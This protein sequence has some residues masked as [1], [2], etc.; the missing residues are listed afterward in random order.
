MQRQGRCNPNS[1][2]SVNINTE[3][4]IWLLDLAA[5]VYA[6]W[7]GIVLENKL[8]YIVQTKPEEL[9]INIK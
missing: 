5:I 4:H 9:S 8:Q 3:T 2:P 6:L 1:G 7:T